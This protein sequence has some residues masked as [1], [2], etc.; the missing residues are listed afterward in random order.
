MRMSF[1]HAGILPAL[2]NGVC[3]TGAFYEQADPYAKPLGAALACS[4][5]R[6]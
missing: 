6:S 5:H 1:S 3:Q 2:G 4:T